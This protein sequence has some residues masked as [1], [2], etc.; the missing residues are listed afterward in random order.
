MHYEIKCPFC[1]QVFEADAKYLLST[2]YRKLSEHLENDHFDQVEDWFK[3]HR[4]K[5]YYVKSSC[6]KPFKGYLIGTLGGTTPLIVKATPEQFRKLKGA[7]NLRELVSALNEIISAMDQ[8]NPQQFAILLQAA[9]L[10][11]WIFSYFASQTTT[12]KVSR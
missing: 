10:I 11:R 2:A 7:K 1:P 9:V 3:Q 12:L 8:T 5:W 4:K 6:L